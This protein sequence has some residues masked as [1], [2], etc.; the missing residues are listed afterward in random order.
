LL[1]LVV[2]LTQRQTAASDAIFE[3]R[4]L[5]LSRFC[6]TLRFLLTVLDYFFCGG[7]FSVS[8][9]RKSSDRR[10]TKSLSRLE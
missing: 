4:Q 10:L 2:V 9:P 6:S 8:G 1:W 3:L 7:N 5:L